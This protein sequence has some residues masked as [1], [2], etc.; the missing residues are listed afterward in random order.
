MP[1]LLLHG[2]NHAMSDLNASLAFAHLEELPAELQIRAESLR[3]FVDRCAELGMETCYTRKSID[4]GAVY[5]LPVKSRDGSPSETIDRIQ[6]RTGLLCERVYPPIPVSPLYRPFTV[7]LYGLALRDIRQ[8]HAHASLLHEQ[9]IAVPHWAFL[10]GP[11]K[12]RQL[13]DALADSEGRFC[14]SMRSAGKPSCT[15]VVLTRDRPEL[16]RRALRTIKE[17]NADVEL[18]V[19]LVNNGA[20]L[21]PR[22]MH[23]LAHLRLDQLTVGGDFLEQL[24]TLQR[25]THLRRLALS[26]I[27]ADFVSFLDDDNFW[28][29]QHLSSLMSA[30]FEKCAAASHSWRTVQNVFGEA[31]PLHT[32]PWARTPIRRSR[33]FEE[34]LSAGLMEDGSSLVRDSA[35][36]PDGTPGMVDMG[37]WLFS[38]SV[39]DSIA[40][41]E[42]FSTDD[43]ENIVGED[44]K[45]LAELLAHGVPIAC[46][47]QATLRYTLGGMSNFS[48]DGGQEKTA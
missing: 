1:A 20:T 5:A 11:E 9:W 36:R 46:T 13:A 32:F 28:E 10:A 42:A 8:N 30:I 37:C 18:S 43:I 29:P 31:V 22:V 6:K 48:D 27:N 39:V 47:R 38:R 7:G 15:V 21:D 23:D 3:V 44:D 25:I 2:A 40:F 14:I 41:Q 34:A 12:V 26:F 19:L 45:L 35:L 17:Q 4:D 33:L 16:L 24:P